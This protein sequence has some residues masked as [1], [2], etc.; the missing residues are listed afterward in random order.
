VPTAVRKLPLDS[1]GPA[2]K[3]CRT[4]I[5]GKWTAA[6]E[7]RCGN[8]GA[9]A[10]I[11][12]PTIYL[13]AGSGAHIPSGIPPCGVRVRPSREADGTPTSRGGWVTRNAA[14]IPDRVLLRRR[15]GQSGQQRQTWDLTEYA[16][17]GHQGDAKP[18]RRRRDPAVRLVDALAQRM[19]TASTV[20]P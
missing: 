8:G 20:V 6:L 11:V 16:V 5:S 13:P 15:S 1:H 19:T 9:A 2:K 17:M 14:R 3:L 7:L 18:Q 4:T 10:S 12:P